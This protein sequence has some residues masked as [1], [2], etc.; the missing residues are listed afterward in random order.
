MYVDARG[1]ESTK[2]C[3]GAND[4]SRWAAGHHQEIVR[5]QRGFVLDYAVLWY[6][7]AVQPRTERTEPANHNGT[8]DA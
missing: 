8:L 1:V 6:A 2:D 7:D 5:F 3:L 4:F